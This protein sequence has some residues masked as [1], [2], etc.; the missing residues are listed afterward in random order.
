MVLN[1][2]VNGEITETNNREKNMD[3]TIAT[4]LC[5]I[6]CLSDILEMTCSAQT[7]QISS[8]SSTASHTVQQFQK[9]RHNKEFDTIW[10]DLEETFYSNNYYCCIM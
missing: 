8:A 5:V 4:N 10:K 7:P 6:T 1:N 3:D 2:A 9:R